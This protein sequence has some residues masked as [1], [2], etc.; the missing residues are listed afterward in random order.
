ML[1]KEAYQIFESIDYGNGFGRFW[2]K[3]RCRYPFHD[4]HTRDKAFAKV[5]I[6]V[7]KLQK[8]P[9]DARLGWNVMYR[10]NK[11]TETTNIEVVVAEIL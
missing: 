5:Q 7:D 8:N 11:V 3:A 6:K 9:P 1:I 10:I 4:Q 2:P